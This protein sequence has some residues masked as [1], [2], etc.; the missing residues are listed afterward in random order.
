MLSLEHSQVVELRKFLEQGI[1]S[2]LS[3]LLDPG[4][5]GHLGHYDARHVPE[6][7]GIRTRQVHFL[8]R[9]S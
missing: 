8:H 3:M 5:C 4:L 1:N 6:H 2:D 9:L 7:V